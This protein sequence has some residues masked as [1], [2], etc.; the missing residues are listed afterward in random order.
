MKKFC[1]SKKLAIKGAVVSLAGAMLV[2]SGCQAKE[3]LDFYKAMTAASTFTNYQYM[4]TMESPQFADTAKTTSIVQ[5]SFD[6]VALKGIV[7]DGDAFS[8]SIQLRID[9]Q[10]QDV[11]Q[12]IIRDDRIYLDLGS[13][14]TT[15]NKLA[16]DSYASIQT[17][18][19]KFKESM[20]QAPD[21]CNKQLE[22][23]GLTVDDIKNR[24]DNNI[25]W[26][27]I[28]LSTVDE[29]VD[30]VKDA[31]SMLKDAISIDKVEDLDENK[32]PEATRLLLQQISEAFE[33]RFGGVEPSFTNVN[34]SGNEYSFHLNNDNMEA[35]LDGCAKF[36]SEDL[37]NILDNSI[38]T[39]NDENMS[40]P[41]KA[42]GDL[43]DKLLE[44]HKTY[45]P[46]DWSNTVEV[47]MLDSAVDSLVKAKSSFAENKDK[48]DF[49]WLSIVSLTGGDGSRVWKSSHSVSVKTKDTALNNDAKAD[50][51]S[52][53]DAYN[54][55]SVMKDVE[56]TVTVTLQEFKD[57]SAAVNA[58]FDPASD[59]FCL[60]TA[61]LKTIESVKTANNNYAYGYDYSLS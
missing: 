2:A 8:A 25:G 37:L 6:G 34:K 58:M 5:N 1:L 56:M 47:S 26:V 46:D 13:I 45:D 39:M 31:N 27:Y 32:Y 51:M 40:E 44:K 15:V 3:V 43:T 30:M 36:A 23:Y 20:D 10:Y 35:F 41:A 53:I 22:P 52:A 9:G 50:M 19:D 4:I 12:I 24:L 17:S 55:G 49:D 42:M 11:T 38:K 61:A 16:P 29:A 14:L 59:A 48:V 21:E 28:S 7:T 18:I 57:V 33:K 60:D 54:V